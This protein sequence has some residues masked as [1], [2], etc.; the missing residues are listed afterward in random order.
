MWIPCH[1]HEHANGKLHWLQVAHVKNPQF[2][3][4]AVI[5]ERQLLPHVL[6]R[7]DVQPL[8]VAWCTYIVNV[9]I[10]SPATLALPFLYGGHTA[11]VAP[12]VVAEQD[13]HV[14]GHTQPGIIV[15]L[16][17]LIQ[18]PQLRC[19]LCRLA[20]DLLDDLSLVA[21]NLLH[22]ACVSLIAHGLI[23][24]AAHADGHDVVSTAHTLDSLAE[25]AVKRL[26]VGS[27][28]PRTPPLAIAS[29]LLMVACHRLVVRGTHHNAH[30][31]GRLQVFGIVGIES[32]TPHGRPEVVAFQ[33]QDKLEHLLIEAMVTVVGTEGILH[34]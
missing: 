16:D 29:I 4:A 7:R 12:I 9:V 18:G 14:V 34:P 2:L 33:S 8:G 22:E 24:I 27:I 5:G 26:L 3:N 6:C 25:E 11:H 19:L 21:D 28:V 23:A 13:G 1:F 17:L 32:P 15:V 30:G 10:Q 20:R 31:I